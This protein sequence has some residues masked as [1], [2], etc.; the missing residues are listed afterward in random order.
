LHSGNKP[1]QLLPN[2]N[3]PATVFFVVV[4]GELLALLLT[5]SQ[6]LS[7]LSWSY[8]GFSS[9]LIQWVSLTSLLIISF[10]MKRS[11][12]Q[13]FSMVAWML[14]ISVTVLT[15]LLN[16]LFDY[17]FLNQPWQALGAETWQTIGKH[18]AAALII[19]AALTR[20]FYLQHMYQM[21]QL[22]EAKARFNALQ[23]RIHPHFLF[24][25]LN[26][27]TCLVSDSAHKAEMMLENLADLLRAS[28]NQ[29][30]T[31]HA[32]KDEITL[33]QKYLDIEQCR[34]GGRLQVHW[35]YPEKI[36][37][38]QV[39]VLLLQ[40]LIENAI[41]HGIFPNVNGGAITISIDNLQSTQISITNPFYDSH[42]QAGSGFHIALNNC[43]ERLKIQF[44]DEAEILTEN[45]ESAWTTQVIIPFQN[46]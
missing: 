24:N 36:P 38:V 35:F 42:T 27:I 11:T 25:A 5:L 22:S 16:F 21:R 26:A 20:Y 14:P 6:P 7:H 28:L 23:A 39:P 33:C 17:F 37:D 41:L 9:L 31:L 34:L 3:N 44:G 15:G 46:S 1:L 10:Y 40:P 2:L 32:L 13:S 29:E 43:R 18:M 45:N 30:K 8:L 19:S 12:Q 4:I